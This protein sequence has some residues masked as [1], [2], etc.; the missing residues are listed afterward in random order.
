MVALSAA[1][2]AA[3][4]RAQAEE[5]VKITVLAVL[6]TDKNSQVDPRL[7]C[8]AEKVQKLRPCLTG[9]SLART[10][11]KSIEVG[12]ECKFPLVDNEV[13]VVTVE[14]GPDMNHWAG[15]TVKAPLMGEICYICCC[16]KYLPL[17]TDYTNRKQE[18]LIVAIMVEPCKK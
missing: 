9:F 12:K 6:A 4:P 17:W 15:L 18:S 8:I 16:G 14:Q 2:L 11:R 13:V 10:S 7:T 5:K 3:S 1:C